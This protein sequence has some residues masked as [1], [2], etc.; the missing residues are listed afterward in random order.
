MG[1][2]QLSRRNASANRGRYAMG[3][4]AV[5]IATA[6]ITAG[7]TI[8]GALQSQLL[9]AGADAGGASAGL[10]VL[11]GAFGLVVTVAA[12]F[13]IANAFATIVADRVRELA[14]L[15]TIGMRRRQVFATV[16]IEG[17]LIGLAGTLAGLVAGS[18][19]GAGLVALLVADASPALPSLSGLVAALVVGLAVTTVAVALPARAATRVAPVA[20]LSQSREST[21]RALGAFRVTMGTAA[22]L[23]GV[24]LALAPTGES[25]GSF[26]VMVFT[27]GA[28]ISFVGM[29][30]LAPLAV[31]GLGRLGSLSASLPPTV[32]LAVSNLDRAPRRVAN[33]VIAVILG[34]T[35]ATGVLVVLGSVIAAAQNQ[36]YADG[37]Y[38]AY[39]LALGLTG[40]TL[41]VSLVGVLNTIVLSV[42]ERQH[43]LTLLRAVGMTVGDIRR[44]VM[45]E[46]VVLAVV[47]VLLGIAFGYLGA[48]VLLSRLADALAVN[49]PWTLVGVV[50][51]LSLGLVAFG[52]RRATRLSAAR[53]NSIASNLSVSV[54]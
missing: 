25:G 43:E 14:L 3:F 6:F 10:R 45:V 18:G 42:R 24:G 5:G 33:T 53:N 4:L 40:F 8:V 12:G 26:A 52:S 32:R 9:V 20:A 15:R 22:L 44:T 29:A 35:L 34:M 38:G 39:A 51:M 27:A 36:G 11:L 16:L 47:G 41:I 48:A 28:L 50:A 37:S 21:G 49:A 54:Q 30:L 7:S 1:P 17:L 23:A 19:F 2:A 13:V 31:P 46:G